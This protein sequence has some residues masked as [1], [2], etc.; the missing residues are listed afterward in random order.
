[1][2]GIENN[3]QT[4]ISENEILADSSGEMSKDKVIKL[5]DFLK[6]KATTAQAKQLETFLNTHMQNGVLLNQGFKLNNEYFNNIL[7]NIYRGNLFSF[8]K[9]IG[10]FLTVQQDIAPFS[11]TADKNYKNECSAVTNEAKNAC[12]SLKTELKQNNEIRQNNSIKSQ[13]N[14]SPKVESVTLSNNSEILYKGNNVIK[15]GNNEYGFEIPL[16]GIIEGLNVN[17]DNLSVTINAYGR[18]ALVGPY[19]ISEFT[20]NIAA[21]KM[22]L[23]TSYGDVKITKIS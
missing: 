15:I 20:K 3:N 1:M 2:S 17:G 11:E 9:K 14:I 22:S 4:P 16:N 10:Q 8:E 6:S 19:S 21:G 18:R 5:L 13:Q 23:K 12:N 7:S